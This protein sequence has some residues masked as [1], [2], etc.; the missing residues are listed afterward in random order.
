MIYFFGSSSQKSLF[1][2]SNKS[3]TPLL[4]SRMYTLSST[5]LLLTL[6][7]TLSAVQAY[8]PRPRQQQA[9]VCRDD[10]QLRALERYSSFADEFCP[11]FLAQT[12]GYPRWLDQWNKNKLFSACSCYEKTATAHGAP[13][14]ASITGT[15]AL[16]ST[17]P[18]PLSSV[19]ATTTA[20]SSPLPSASGLGPSASVPLATESTAPHYSPS[21]FPS[22]SVTRGPYPFPSA[23]GRY[24][25]SGSP[26]GGYYPSGSASGGYYPSASS[27]GRLP[28]GSISRGLLSS[29]SAFGSSGF[30]SASTGSPIISSPA[31]TSLPSV[32]NRGVSALS[33]NVSS[34]ISASSTIA[35]AP[36]S[37]SLTLSQGAS[38]LAS[39]T[40]PSGT[41][42]LPAGDT[43]P[44]QPPGAGPGKRGLVYDGR[45]QDGWSS[46][47]KSSKYVTYGS[48]GGLNRGTKLDKSFSFVPTL[49]VDA[50]LNNAEW[51]TQV[52]V[53]IEGGTKAL[54]A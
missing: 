7:V 50:D 1:P 3:A 36:T 26:S 17:A 32:P 47:F 27:T 4:Q 19:F 34:L 42:S 22:G 5:F 33:S 31:S 30:L 12:G 51:N 40:A 48:N 25:P 38:E 13:S 11:E 54:F 8:V 43:Y 9:P 23:T 53:L 20:S 21:G 35:S 18:A 45:T 29:G 44:P 46:L 49:V 37:A 14:T 24:Y 6:S 52:P 10:S 41:S 39:S 28:S 2:K 15:L 16:S